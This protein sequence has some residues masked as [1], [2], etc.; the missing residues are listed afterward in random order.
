MG[1]L[2]RVKEQ[3]RESTWHISVLNNCALLFI[4]YSFP[5]DAQVN[6]TVVPVLKKLTMRQRKLNTC[7]DSDKY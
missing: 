5:E 2:R 3:E 4:P 6:C 1:S 7:L